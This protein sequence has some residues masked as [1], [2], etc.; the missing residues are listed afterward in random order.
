MR[1]VDYFPKNEYKINMS[2]DT[3][4]N[5]SLTSIKKKTLQNLV[6]YLKEKKARW[7]KWDK[8]GKTA[9]ELLKLTGEK[10]YSDVISWGF[11]WGPIRK[12]NGFYI[13]EGTSWAN[14]NCQNMPL[15][16]SNGELASIARKF[17][18]IDWYVE[19]S[20]EYDE[21]GAVYPPLFEG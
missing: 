14:E 12:G 8:E 13:M 11:N 19:Y 6:R 9:D 2:C 16:W 5:I 15:R 10:E 3:E 20:N 17:P 1:K 4:Y 18:D 21:E 7:D